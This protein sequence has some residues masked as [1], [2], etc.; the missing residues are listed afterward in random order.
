[1]TDL[2]RQSVEEF[3]SKLTVRDQLDLAELKLRSEIA[4]KIIAEFIR[5]NYA[6][7]LFLLIIFAIES[8]F[9]LF[10]KLQPN[11]R[12]INASVITTLIGATTV[13]FGAIALLVSQWLFPKNK[14]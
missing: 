6:I 3:E 13:Q 1:M 9:L 14:N 10:E 11:G 12:I 2:G 8:L 7:L 4:Q 5:A